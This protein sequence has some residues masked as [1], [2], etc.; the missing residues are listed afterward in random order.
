M[1]KIILLKFFF[2]SASSVRSWTFNP[3]SGLVD[4]AMLGG[5]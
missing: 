5:D 1:L 2:M 3:G 4:I